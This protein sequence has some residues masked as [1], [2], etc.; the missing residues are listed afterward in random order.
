MASIIV[1]TGENEGKYYPLGR[2]PNVIGRDEAV[3]IQI[4]DKHVSRKHAQI[5]YDTDNKKY[6]ILDMKSRHGVFLNGHKIHEQ[7]QLRD[8]DKI[9]IG[10]STLVFY[11]RDF[12][13]RENALAH[14]KKVGERVRTTLD[15]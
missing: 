6:H 11:L 4:L 7:A 12:E 14:Y 13:D 9:G 2:R 3:P 5:R 1:I 10:N 15:E 8:G